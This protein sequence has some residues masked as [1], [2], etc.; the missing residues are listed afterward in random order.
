MKI[1]LSPAKTFNL[2]ANIYQQS[3]NFLETTKYI[4]DNVDCLKSKNLYK[5]FE[6]YD[7]M[8][9]KNIKKNSL[10]SD[11]V[12]FINQHFYILSALYGALKPNDLIHPYRLDFNMKQSLG[13]LYNL[14]QDQVYKLIFEEDIILNLASSEF[15]KLIS[16]FIDVK[17]W[18][19]VD[20]VAYKNQE[21]KH[22]STISKK[23]RGLMSY[24]IIKNKIVDYHDIINFNLE[25]FKYSI[26]LST[27]YKYVF[28]LSN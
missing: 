16:K 25:N 21:I 26:E 13:N 9:F 12:A 2:S 18:I 27:D 3:E 6:L 28:V 4:L 14:W 19:D 20:F 10:N 1:I 5:A 11:D 17:Y 22:H 7:G 23:G 15:S 8:V 24:Y